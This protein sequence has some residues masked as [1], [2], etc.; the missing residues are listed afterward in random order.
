[1][2]KNAIP[3]DPLPPAKSSGIRLGTP[4]LSTRGMGPQE[5]RLIAD[6]M[7]TILG[8]SA[9]EAKRDQIR[10]KVKELC[11]QFPLYNHTQHWKSV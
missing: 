5:M 2:N 1:M 10:E 4:A 8:N 11:L 9:D 3:F 7:A 6:F